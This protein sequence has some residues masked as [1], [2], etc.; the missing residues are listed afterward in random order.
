MNWFLAE[1]YYVSAAVAFAF[2][3]VRSALAKEQGRIEPPVLDR[4]GLH[5][6]NRGLNR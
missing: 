3:D 2:A 1:L 5:H 4:E 6:G